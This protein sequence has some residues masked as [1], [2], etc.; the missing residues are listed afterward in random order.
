MLLACAVLALAGCASMPDS[1]DV[2]RVDSTPSPDVDSQVRVYGVSPSKGEQPTE[3]VSGFLEAT[4]SDEENFGTAKEYLT[5]KEA[6]RWD[7]FAATKVLAQAPKLRV[8]RSADRDGEDGV[9]VVLSG[10]QVATVNAKHAYQPDQGAY[11]GRI[12]LVK[13]GAEWRID[14]LPP[15]LV[16]GQSDFQRIYGSVNR[17]YFAELGPDAADSRVGE[18]VL[19]AD[20][21]YLRSRIDPVTSIVKALLDGPT[22]WLGP[23]VT[24]AFPR[25][26]T[27]SGSSEKLALDDDNA[28]T[29]PLSAQAA[30]VGQAQCQRMAAQLL[31][32]VQD[33]ASAK[34]SSVTLERGDGFE[35]CKLSSEAAGVYAPARV[36]GSS[37]HQYYVDADHRMVRL[38]GGSDTPQPVPG[39]F[40]RKGADLGSVAVSRDDRIAAG[41][42]QDG[43]SLYV[44]GLEPGAALG[45]IRLHSKGKSAKDGLT[46][47]S[48]DGL[49]NLW[50]ADRDPAD[51]RL[52]VMRQG[53]A[54]PQQVAVA[55]LGSGRIEALRVSADGTRIAM[56]IERGGRTTL[57]L[58]RV[59]RRG[60]ADAP[61]LSVAGL[62]PIAPQLEDVDAV[63]WAGTSR[64]VVAGRESHGVQQLQYVETDG[65]PVNVPAV[66]GPNQV[67]ALGASENETRPLI[68]QTLDG[69]LRL[70]PNADWQ[71]VATAGSA[72]VYPG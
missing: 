11:E 60:S 22:G 40:G 48:W 31:F 64:L 20:P 54:D 13:T 35:L 29:V 12:H 49:G 23:V 42:T 39:P 45:D 14:S 27:L 32:T 59:E 52:L 17:Y 19:V 56:L 70:Y 16:L 47:P 8:E 2:S 61:Q 58:G 55:G 24:T 46:P 21:V 26:T 41:V 6:K 36:N 51:P 33:E 15:G 1:G 25:G 4:T 37:E 38:S 28:L 30:R 53:I 18:D 67:E 71:T 34:V 69:I 7:P 9:T 68:A 10:T 65:S 63:A 72:P 62:R 66:P 50:V 57:Q 43:R 3:L 44:A 5:G